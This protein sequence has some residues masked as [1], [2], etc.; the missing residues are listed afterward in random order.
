MDSP[1]SPANSGAKLSALG[2]SDVREVRDVP[3]RYHECVT[4]GGW[5]ERKK[6]GDMLVS[7]YDLRTRVISTDDAAERARQL[8]H[9]RVTPLPDH[10]S[11]FLDKAL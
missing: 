11:M 8:V 6:R 7:I 4:S 9:T 10:D 3:V 5:R 1:G 2:V